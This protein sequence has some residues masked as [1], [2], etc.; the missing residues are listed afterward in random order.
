MD[1]RHLQYMLTVAEERSFTKAA[2]KL[3]IAQPSL[4]QY[5]Q[6]IE[7]DLGVQLFDRTTAPLSL[8]FAGEAFCQAASRILEI[9]QQLHVQIQEI[10]D[11][12][13]GRITIGIT[14][15]RGHILLPMILPK[16]KSKFPG[17]E[18]IVKEAHLTE[19]MELALKGATDLSIVTLPINSLEF[20]WEPIL[21]ERIVL[22]VPQNH[23]LNNTTRQLSSRPKI[24]LSDLKKESFILLKQERKLRKIIDQLFLSER[25]TPNIIFE[26]DNVETVLS[27]VASGMGI[28]I[29]TDALPAFSYPNQFKFF[30]LEPALAPR[31]IA[32]AYRKDRYL[33]KAAQ[34]FI[35]ITK[36]IAT[37]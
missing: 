11:S 5:I 16:F 13:Q 23:W 26:S 2:Q 14:P 9:R 1:F 37:L 7:Q 10:I 36:E 17:F 4:S 35:L 18:V 19:L 12:K 22:I 15:S 31:T 33:P 34:D 32:I 28:T 20:H 24:A 3:F 30:E 6:R 25:F 29:S 21:S 8:T 27:L